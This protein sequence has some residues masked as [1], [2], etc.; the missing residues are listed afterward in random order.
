MAGLKILF[1]EDDHVISEMYSRALLTAGYEVEAAYNG[2][3]GLMKAQTGQFPLILLDIM[4]P[5]KTGIE[6]LTACRGPE[7]KGPTGK[8]NY[9][10]HQPGPRRRLPRSR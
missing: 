7:G 5:E 8:Q 3:D 2:N 6:I 9:Y 4:M 10:H 1:V